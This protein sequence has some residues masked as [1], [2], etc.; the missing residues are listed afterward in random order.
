MNSYNSSET[1][2][3]SFWTVISL[4][5]CTSFRC[6]KVHIPDTAKAVN[7]HESDLSRRMVA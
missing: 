6:G 2:T 1:S 7:A 5:I 3:T 4:L